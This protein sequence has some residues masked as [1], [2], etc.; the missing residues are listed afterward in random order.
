MQRPQA[1][2]HRLKSLYL[3]PSANKARE[4]LQI[5][6]IFQQTNFKMGKESKW[7]KKILKGLFFILFYSSKTEYVNVAGEVQ[8]RQ[9]F[10]AQK[11]FQHYEGKRKD[12]TD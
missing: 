1:N 2:E 9:F 10:R 8:V 5:A 12:E 4:R 7:F 6:H 11:H 3:S